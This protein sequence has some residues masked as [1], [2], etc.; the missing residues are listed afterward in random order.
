[1]NFSNKR[2]L[3]TGASRGIGLAHSRYFASLGANVVMQARPETESV[4]KELV[5]EIRDRGNRAEYVC[6]DIRDSA[7]L[8][9][10]VLKRTNQLDAIVHNAGGV[11]DASIAKMTEHAWQS[12][13]DINLRSAFQLARAAW[14]HFKERNFGRLVFTSSSAGL[15]GN[16]GQANYSASKMGL[17]GLARTIAIE[18]AK[19]NITAN[20]IAPLAAT[21]MNKGLLPDSLIEHAH[22]EKISPLVAYLCH[23]DCVESGSVFEVAGGWVGKVHISCSEGVLLSDKELNPDSIATRW[24]E[25]C[26]SSKSCMPLSAKGSLDSI[27]KKIGIS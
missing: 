16:F 7:A 11:D 22:A 24:S 27:I 14:P 8:V 25:I 6:G 9:N 5:A 17:I 18:G 15:Y 23:E 1:M 12:I 20:C 4:L 21:D 2:I 3:I 19:Y 10:T 26:D 13:I